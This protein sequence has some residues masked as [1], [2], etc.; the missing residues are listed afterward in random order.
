M[1]DRP[2]NLRSMLAEAKDLSELM[3]DIAYAALYFGD[4]DMAEEVRDLED[5]MSDLVHD[6]R[7]VC[8]LGA[9]RPKEAE[10]MASVLQVIS[11]IARIADDAVGIARIVTHRLGIPRELVAD[12]AEAEEVNH[13]V[14]VSAGSQ[15]ANRRLS[16]LQLPVGV[17]M[18]VVAVRRGRDWDTDIDGDTL[19][20]PGDVLFLKGAPAG[21]TRLR[22]L[23]DAPSWE[24]P[25]VEG[26]VITDLDRAVD[27]LV[28]MKNLSEAAVGLAYSALVLADA[29]L[30][31]EVRHLEA[32]L[33]EMKDRLE[34]WVLRASR[35]PE[36]DPSPLRGLLHLAQAA[37]DIGDQASQMVWLI[38]RQEEVHPILGIA[39]GDSDEVVMRVP[40]AAGSSIEGKSLSELHLNIEPGFNVLAIRRAGGYVY[41]PRGNVRLQVG[42]A[43]LATGPE[44]GREKLALMCGYRL[45]IDDE[46]GEMELEPIDGAARP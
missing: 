25:K 42:D 10:G 14:L 9:R 8:V 11:A 28:E 21:I 2:R 27:V 35:N 34:L 37:E 3:V 30:A 45:W 32:R 44:E 5:T 36:V 19:L 18:R 46:T 6:M 7:T 41:R 20:V 12:L 17:G 40:V 39:L 26:G 4:P 24:P 15:M 38:E 43:L 16:D 22:E 31:A 33:D 1:D 29:G 23:A 13:R